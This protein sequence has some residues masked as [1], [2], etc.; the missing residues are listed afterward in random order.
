MASQEVT[1]PRR[2]GHPLSIL[3][4]NLL[5]CTSLVQGCAENGWNGVGWEGTV[6][7]LAGGGVRVVNPER[8]IWAPGD[9]WG[10]VEELRIGGGETEGP[11]LFS[12]IVAL[13]TD[14]EGR[15]WVLERG[16]REIR[17]FGPDGS[18]IR[19][20]GRRG[21][22]PG[23]FNDP[24]GMG[25]G[26]DD[27]LW[28]V[29]PGNGRFSVFDREGN[30]LRSHPRR[31]GG[32]MLPWP[33]G[34]GPEGEVF[35]RIFVAGGG[36]LVRFSPDLAAADT[37]ALPTPP[38]RDLFE[39]TR[40]GARMSVAVPF[41]PGLAMTLDLRGYLWSGVTDRSR[42]VRTNLDGDTLLV[43][44]WPMERQPV[45]AQDREEV[46][47]SLE[48][49]TQQGGTVDARRIPSLKPA[50]TQILLAE[51]GHVWVTPGARTVQGWGRL[52]VIDPDGRW[53]GEARADPPIFGWPT[54][55]I[56]T[57]FVLAVVRDEME[58]P[59]VVRYRIER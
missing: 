55:L 6:D 10:L 51:D 37:F 54:P 26:L 2:P 20:V 59:Y 38:D 21:G 33:G 45:T 4:T 56:G 11:E 53:L 48:W 27:E 34:F 36:A 50:F 47:E 44:E 14:S 23:E 16:V 30:F 52:H 41:S 17:I 5:L 29:D 22:G 1:G 57:D 9:E 58:V 39:L 42:L 7:T 15:I 25:W 28:V 18:H 12:D 49:F 46:L 31:I 13:E 8:P 35:D 43:T 19:S 3:S 40:N 32:Y 24:V